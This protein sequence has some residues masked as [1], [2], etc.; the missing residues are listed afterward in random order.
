METSHGKYRVVN[1]N[2][3]ALRAPLGRSLAAHEGKVVPF[4]FVTM[5]S[6]LLL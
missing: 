4:L 6:T 5:E 1:Q 3:R 2:S